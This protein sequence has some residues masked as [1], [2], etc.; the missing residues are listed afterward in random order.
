MIF[1]V[2]QRQCC[3]PYKLE[4]RRNAFSRQME[5]GSC[6]PNAQVERKTDVAYSS[7][8]FHI[9]TDSLSR[10]GQIVLMEYFL[11]PAVF[12]TDICIWIQRWIQ[13]VP[14]VC[15]TPCLFSANQQALVAN[16]L[17]P[18]SKEGCLLYKQFPM[19]ILVSKGDSED[20]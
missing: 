5:H 16:D 10:N 20:H 7:G 18:R 1:Y 3:F 15:H 13:F 6:A 17:V 8:G 11:H 4:R 2:K 12:E 9:L 14:S 19:V